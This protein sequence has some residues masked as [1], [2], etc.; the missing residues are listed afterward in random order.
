MSHYSTMMILD[1]PW[2]L[3]FHYVNTV[4]AGLQSQQDFSGYY[5]DKFVTIINQS[6]VHFVLAVPQC[7]CSNAKPSAPDTP[8]LENS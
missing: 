2:K 4:V 8:S 6:M 5:L 3:G 1:T 7:F